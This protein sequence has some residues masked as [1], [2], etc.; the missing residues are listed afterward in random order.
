MLQE[1]GPATNE[2]QK[3]IDEIVAIAR[4]RLEGC[5]MGT[6][7]DMAWRYCQLLSDLGAKTESEQ[8]HAFY[9]S[10]F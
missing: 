2:R 6:I 5:R 1:Q 4:G 8:V 9:Q 10:L 3:V 7:D